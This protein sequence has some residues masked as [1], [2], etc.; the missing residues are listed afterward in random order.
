MANIR[1]INS[2]RLSHRELIPS[3]G[4]TCYFVTYD[5]L[6]HWLTQMTV[7]A[8]Y[9]FFV[10]L[11]RL[12]IGWFSVITGQV[13]SVWGL[14]FHAPRIESVDAFNF[15]TVTEHATTVLTSHVFQNCS[16]DFVRA[17]KS[18]RS[19]D[20]YLM[21]RFRNR[22]INLIEIS[23]WS[24]RWHWDPDI[25]AATDRFRCCPKTTAVGLCFLFV[26]NSSFST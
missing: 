16:R 23:V 26:S 22:R 17:K 10:F 18:C 4:N 11:S 15:T 13:L 25:D 24:T 9:C 12:R 20:Q 14:V 8:L 2:S 5:H 1:Q 6:F 7:W 3:L 21:K 19:A